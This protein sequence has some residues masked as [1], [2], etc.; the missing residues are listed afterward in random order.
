MRLSLVLCLFCYL[1]LAGCRSEEPAEDVL[2][3]AA[4]VQMLLESSAKELLAREEQ[5]ID[6]FLVRQR[7]EMKTTGSGLRY[8]VLKPGEGPLADY[9]Q[10]VRVEYSV[11]LLNG[12][13]VYSSSEDEPLQFR[14][15]RGGAVTGLD[16]GIRMLNEGAKAIFVVP[17]HL[18]HGIQGDGRN[19]PGRATLV[20]EVELINIL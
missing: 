12:D 17:Y 18:A 4:R 10:Q 15:G 8:K 20:Y 3:D 16:E 19:I 5:A 14:V 11:Y 1:V 9:A 7:L 13:L 6:D 2:P